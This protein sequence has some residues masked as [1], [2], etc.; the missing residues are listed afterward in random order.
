MNYKILVKDLNEVRDACSG[1]LSVTCVSS[2]MFFPTEHSEDSACSH[3]SLQKLARSLS[4]MGKADLW[5]SKVYLNV[6]FR[7]IFS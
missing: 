5:Y 2:S 3:R 7:N 4:I 6:Q 1:E